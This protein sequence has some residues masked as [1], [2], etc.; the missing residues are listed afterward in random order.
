MP[1]CPRPRTAA[2]LA[3]A[4]HRHPGADAH[5][6]PDSHT[7]PHAHADADAD[8]G[9]GEGAGH[10]AHHVAVQAG[11]RVHPGQEP[12]RQAVRHRLDAEH[13]ARHGVVA[14]RRPSRCALAL[15]VHTRRVGGGVAPT[16]CAWS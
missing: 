11:Q 2:D 4:A 14:E 12:G 9:R 3:S 15:R 10:G 13:E 7:Y 5:A 1:R 16:S 8:Q 6:D